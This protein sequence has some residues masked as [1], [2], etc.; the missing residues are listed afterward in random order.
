MSEHPPKIPALRREQLALGELPPAAR[1]QL[2]ARIGPEV[3]AEIAA[4]RADDAE[5]L[6]TYPPARIRA[7][8][9]RRAA[10]RGPSAR[11]IVWFGAPALAAAAIV[12]LIVTRPGD[13]AAPL[14]EGP[15]DFVR[16]A[17]P[18]GTRIKGLQ[19]HLVVHRQDGAA[20]VQLQDAAEARAQ[21]VLQVSYVAAG[22]P[23][24]VVVSLDGGGAVTLHFPADP[25]A[26]TALQQGGAVRLAQAYELDAAPGF[27]R[28]VL[29]T[30]AAPLDP[31]Q[32][33]A[34]ARDL[35][36]ESGS[37]ARPLA[38][39]EGWQQSS[40]LVRKAAR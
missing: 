33:L 13:G 29:V 20:A 34:A 38:L 2:R 11:R 5:I 12:L 10:A 35:A 6:A 17:D 23:H 25:T 21:D 1:D 24:G 28:F 39:P 15:G 9:E 22:A 16:A 40:F 8:V 27:E 3:D 19:P 30:A 31:A 18:G 37:D 36:H 4:L 7:E 26:S 32:V 14:G